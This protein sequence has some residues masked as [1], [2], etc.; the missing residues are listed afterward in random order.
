M[1]ESIATYL[2]STYALPNSVN[3][4]TNPIGSTK[5][6]PTMNASPYG[7]PTRTFLHA[8]ITGHVLDPLPTLLNTALLMYI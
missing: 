8:F 6:A 5:Q 2:R 1:M 4:A 3:L 7:I